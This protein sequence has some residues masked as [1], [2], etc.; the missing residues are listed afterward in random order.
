MATPGVYQIF[1]GHSNYMK[2]FMQV[3][4]ATYTVYLI[5]G[6]IYIL[7]DKRKFPFK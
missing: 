1:M 2:I 3:Q 7:Y 6:I 5:L 4:Y